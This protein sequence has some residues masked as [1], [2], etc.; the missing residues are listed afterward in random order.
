M[1]T[2]SLVSVVIPTFNRAHCIA[3]TIESALAQ[4]HRDLEIVVVDDGSRD[5]T[6][7]VVARVEARDPRVRYV[8]QDN[9]GVSAARNRGFAEARGEFVA[10]LDSDDLWLPDKL[11]AQVRCLEALPEAGMIWTDMDAFFPDGSVAGRRYLRTMY[12]AY[13][14]FESR[15]Q[16]F[17]HVRP[18]SEIDA[19]LAKRLDDPKLYSGDIFSEMIL[20][21]LVHTSTVLLRRE[22]L[23]RVGGFDTT[24]VDAGEDYDFHLRTCREGPVAYLDVVSIAYRTGSPDQI[25]AGTNDIQFARSFLAT[26]QPVI[27][28]DR[29][30]IRLPRIMIEEV[31]A[32]AHAWL[33]G[34]L[35][36]AG[37]MRAARV[38]LARSLR[39]KP[40]QP[41]VAAMLA[42]ALLPSPVGAGVH[43][44]ARAIKSRLR[45]R[46]NGTA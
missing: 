46:T 4:T 10:L 14:W 33:G 3:A 40:N 24:I 41:R 20:G 44:A 25:T 30:R 13:R 18:L 28:R 21:N 35:Y 26:I 11:A 23:E 6:A 9:A 45:R 22:R 31:L 12:S 36:E 29:E 42:L 39:H 16:L 32:E 8:H 1:S 7:A 19:P 38:E 5:D 34:G 27:A 17:T 2:K 43:G 15:E 37:E